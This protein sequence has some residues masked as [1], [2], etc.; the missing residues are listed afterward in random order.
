MHNVAQCRMSEFSSVMNHEICQYGIANAQLI[1][2][3]HK[4]SKYISYCC[5]IKFKILGYLHTVYFLAQYSKDN[6]WIPDDKRLKS[7]Q[8][9]SKMNLL[10]KVELFCINLWYWGSGQSKSW[11]QLSSNTRQFLLCTMCINFTIPIQNADM[12]LLLTHKSRCEFLYT[13]Y[14]CWGE[15]T[16]KEKIIYSYSRWWGLRK[17]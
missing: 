4:W 1:S 8:R 13:G 5:L 15:T 11:S 12:L 6:N 10:N 16:E 14:G 9:N 2:K 17:I 3:N 7:F